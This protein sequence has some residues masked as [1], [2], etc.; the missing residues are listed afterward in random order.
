M[1]PF[2]QVLI[3]IIGYSIGCTA[4]IIHLMFKLHKA[5]QGIDKVIKNYVDRSITQDLTL[6][7]KTPFILVPSEKKRI[8][9]VDETVAKESNEWI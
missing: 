6:P 2:Q 9:I 7:T 3:A 8:E 5:D 1:Q 4:L